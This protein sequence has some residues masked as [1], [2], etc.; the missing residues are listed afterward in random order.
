[1]LVKFKKFKP[2]VYD[3]D[4]DDFW[5]VK[6]WVVH[7]EK[8]FHDLYTEECNKVPLAIHCLEG[9]ASSWWGNLIK[10]RYEGMSYPS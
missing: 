1:M 4:I 6:K 7:R 10:E 8:L 9:E 2:P 5:A 3:G